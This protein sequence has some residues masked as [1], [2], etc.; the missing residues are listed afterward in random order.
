MQYRTFKLQQLAAP[1]T[2][3]Y[4]K[5]DGTTASFYN[6]DTLV[7][8]AGGAVSSYSIDNDYMVNNNSTI[9]LARETKAVA[10]QII[11]L[12]DDSGAYDLGIVTNVDNE[13]LQILYKPMMELFN[14][15]FLNPARESREMSEESEDITYKYD[16]IIQTGQIIGSYYC[17]TVTDRYLRLPLFIRNS[18][19]GSTNGEYNVPAIWTYKDNTFNMKDWLIDLFDTHNVV[20]QFKLVF[21]ATERA[22][23]EIYISRNANENYRLI[24]ANVHG[25]TIKQTEETEVKATVC[26]VIDQNTKALASIWYLTIDN[27]VTNNKTHSKRMQP[28]KLTVAEWDSTN[29]EGVTAEDVAK[30]ALLFSDYNHY[31]NIGISRESSMVPKNL[32]IGDA[33]KIVPEID[34]MTVGQTIETEY[35]DRVFKSIYTGR[36]ES[37]ASSEVTYI[38]GKIRVNY[39]DIIQMKNMKKIRS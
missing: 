18:G 11:A 22:Y 7:Y 34:E 37:S 35:S 26:Y 13:K 36:K 30:D 24:K 14:N 28:F 27:T 8:A 3:D 17:T 19:G 29:E 15:E 21:E 33:V 25:V 39:T 31:I 5:A 1:Y 2:W 12:I 32:Q 20:L 10:G 38:F 9:H 4:T 23:I 16:G 6:Y